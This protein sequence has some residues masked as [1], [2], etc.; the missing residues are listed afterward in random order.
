VLQ[1]VKVCRL[2]IQYAMMEIGKGV[3]F[4][5]RGF[6]IEDKDKFLLKPQMRQ[7]IEDFYAVCKQNDVKNVNEAGLTPEEYYQSTKRFINVQ[8]EGNMAFRKKTM[9][10]PLPSPKYSNADLAILTNGVQGANDFKAHWLGWEAQDFELILDLETVKQPQ[11]IQ[12]STLY[13]PKSW[14]LH[15]KSVTCSVS[16]DGYNFRTLETQTVEG[17]QRKENV[18]HNFSFDKNTGACRYI[19]FEIKGT[20]KLFNWHPSAG[21]GSWVFVDEIVVR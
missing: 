14:I 20:L 11:N 18:T 6:Y 9:A 2:P 17:E 7:L 5:A 21:G 10:N 15:P 8:V 13:D 16:E 3:M 12:I 1:R 19:K 4:G